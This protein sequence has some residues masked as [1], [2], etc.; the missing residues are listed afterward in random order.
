MNA[1]ESLKS[2][3]YSL[4]SFQT[5]FLINI[6]FTDIICWKCIWSSMKTILSKHWPSTLPIIYWFL[7]KIADRISGNLERGSSVRMQKR[8]W[9]LSF[10]HNS[11]H[12]FRIQ[13]FG[14]IWFLFLLFCWP[15]YYLTMFKKNSSLSLL[16]ERN[17]SAKGR[18]KYIRKALV[19][20][21]GRQS[22]PRTHL[23]IFLHLPKS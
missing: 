9:P 3:N 10:R 12:L 20:D 15:L 5:Y 19:R 2:C 17:T 22:S 1:T 16:Y 23:E 14:S 18:V 4:K 21:V 7:W 11:C 13:Y 8:I 6:S